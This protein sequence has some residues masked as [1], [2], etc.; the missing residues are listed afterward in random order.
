MSSAEINSSGG[1]AIRIQPDF[2]GFRVELSARRRT[3]VELVPWSLR[4]LG[5]GVE[6]PHVALADPEGLY[7]EIMERLGRGSR[8]T[9]KRAFASLSK[10]SLTEGIERHR[11]RLLAHLPSE[12]YRSQERVGREMF[13]DRN[14]CG[15][16]MMAAAPLLPICYL[17]ISAE[18]DRDTTC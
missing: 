3:V 5:A 18:A 2:F 17:E 11:L 6:A 1:R 8:Q 4:V 14:L 12:V 9:A 13:P 16:L 10:T 15:I 7:S